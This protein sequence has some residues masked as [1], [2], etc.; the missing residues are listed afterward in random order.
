VKGPVSLEER[1]RDYKAAEEASE[2][3][4]ERW[5]SARAAGRVPPKLEAEMDEAQRT[6]TAAK[7][8]YEGTLKCQERA[9]A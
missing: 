4:A 7:G 1:L 8:R 9:A 2:E 3:V 5:L 6:L